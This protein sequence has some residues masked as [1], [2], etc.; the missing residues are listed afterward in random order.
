MTRTRYIVLAAMVAVT[1]VGCGSKTESAIM[2]AVGTWEHDAAFHRDDVMANYQ[3]TLIVS[4]DSTFTL[5]ISGETSNGTW[6][7]VDNLLTLTY[8]EIN[9]MFLGD[10][11]TAE[12]GMSAGGET[13]QT[14]GTGSTSVFERVAN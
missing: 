12:L 4:S 14:M 2:D 8:S 11:I 3:M 10:G 13:I 1:L 5:E 7:L 9:G 6:V